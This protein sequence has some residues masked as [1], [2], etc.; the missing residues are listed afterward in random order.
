[1][2]DTPERP[3]DLRELFRVLDEH[4]VDYLIVGGVADAR[5]GHLF[6]AR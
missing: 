2:S 1:V 4:G 5:I 6:N 3:L